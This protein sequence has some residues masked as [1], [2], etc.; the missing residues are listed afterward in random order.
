VLIELCPPIISGPKF[1]MKTVLPA[2]GGLCGA[3]FVNKAFERW[4]AFD[5]FPSK[6]ETL[7]E[8]SG[9]LGFHNPQDFL[10]RASVNFEHAKKAFPTDSRY[11]VQV[12]GLGGY[13]PLWSIVLSR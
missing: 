7:G 4:L 1:G 5:Y 3:V 2:A 6:S 12:L 9:S 13:K 11:S 10:T 8:I